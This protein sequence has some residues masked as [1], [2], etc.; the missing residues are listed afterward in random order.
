MLKYIGVCVLNGAAIVLAWYS[1][2]VITLALGGT[3]TPKDW[4]TVACAAAAGAGNVHIW[5][6]A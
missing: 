2:D 3:P 4:W 1:L 5:G 6:N